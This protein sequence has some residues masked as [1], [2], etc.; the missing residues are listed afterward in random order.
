MNH[1]VL[2]EP[3]R[4]TCLIVGRFLSGLYFVL[5][6]LRKIANYAGTADYMAAH[7]V[8]FIPLLLPLTI[9]LQL[10]LGVAMIIGYRTQLAAFLLAGLVLVISIYM[11][12]F[13]AYP[14]G[15]ERA[16]EMQNFIK[17]LAIMA[18]LL[19]IAG[20]GGA[21]R[22]GLSAAPE[23]GRADERIAGKQ[24]EPESE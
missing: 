23:Q 22:R 24:L 21:D 5:P 18:G 7:D 15:M 2:P 9:A 14:D 12:N 16:H 6:G 13:W 10:T 1:S 11:H 8:P 20:V 3:V 17:N 4:L 19:V